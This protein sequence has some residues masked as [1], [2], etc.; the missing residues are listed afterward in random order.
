EARF[1]GVV[2]GGDV[3][4]DHARFHRLASFL[5]ASFGRRRGMEPV[6]SGG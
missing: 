6:C 3:S 4:F 5:D 1:G 2:F